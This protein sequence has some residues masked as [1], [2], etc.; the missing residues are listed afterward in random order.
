MLVNTLYRNENLRTQLTTAS[1]G[2]DLFAQVLN[3]LLSQKDIHTNVQPKINYLDLGLYSSLNPG[4][5][6]GMGMSA[7]PIST[8]EPFRFQSIDP[9][10]INQVLDGKLTGMGG[11]IVRA[12][13][14]HNI[15]PALLTAIAQH[16]TGNGASRA[17]MEK[18]NV[19]GMMGKNG[20]KSYGSVEESIMD[21][22]RNLS[23][24]YL[25]QG[26][27]SISQIAAKY[28]PVGATND[29]TNLNNHWVS[30]V[31]RFINQIK[32]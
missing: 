21:M 1:E 32:A 15:D 27:S 2:N 22:A 29:P 25:G 23:K 30:G 7:M 14:K 24:N 16:E 26:F 11:A 8:G 31:T 28:A 13:Q 12:G 18:N 5:G 9:E 4:M 6:M 10:K 17:A 3:Q 19:A 20:L